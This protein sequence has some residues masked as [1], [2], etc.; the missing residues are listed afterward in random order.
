MYKLTQ[1]QAELLFGVQI[2]QGWYFN[3]VQDINGDWFISEI[4]VN[5]CD[6]D[7]VKQLEQVQFIAKEYEN[8]N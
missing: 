4:E 1:T 6:I 2:S 3:P 7:W 8:I 5:L